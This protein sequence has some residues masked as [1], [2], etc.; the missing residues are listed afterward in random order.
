MRYLKKFNEFVKERTVEKRFPD[1][2]RSD[3]LKDEAER[4]YNSLK[5]IINKIGLNNDNANDIV[6][7]CYDIIINL[8]RA[9]M[10]SEGFFSSGKGAH[11]AEISYLRELGFQEQ[12]VQF[13]NQLRYFRNGILY[14]GKRF[15]KEYAEKVLDFLKKIHP[16]II[17]VLKSKKRGNKFKP[18]SK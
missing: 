10:L 15:D 6:E 16:K 13:S 4:K 18:A 11:E 14:Y 17:S 12:E 3:N 2:Q 9:K 7:Y 8:I 1:N 5:V